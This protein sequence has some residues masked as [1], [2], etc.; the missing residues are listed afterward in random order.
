MYSVITEPKNT[1]LHSR[2]YQRLMKW[3]RRR[4]HELG[5]DQLRDGDPMDP[6]HPYN[7][8]FDVLCKEADQLWRTERNYWLS[9]LQLSHAFFQMKDP[10]Q[11]DEFIA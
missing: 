7:Q 8:A 10:I 4:Q 5:L 1:S 6:H 11:Q 3:F 9:P 2:E